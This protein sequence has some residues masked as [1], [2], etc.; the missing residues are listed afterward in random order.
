MNPVTQLW[1]REAEVQEA[2]VE[3]QRTQLP[4]LEYVPAT[5]VR[6]FVT[7]VG[8]HDEHPLRH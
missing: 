6:Q 2:Q 4:E 1:H 8:S 7:F 3:G 5:Q